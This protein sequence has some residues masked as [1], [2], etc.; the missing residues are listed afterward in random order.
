MRNSAMKS[1][2]TVRLVRP[3]CGAIRGA[4]DRYNGALEALSKRTRMAL[5]H[6]STGSIAAGITGSYLV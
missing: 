2:T 4:I 3:P 5:P 1:P 6:K